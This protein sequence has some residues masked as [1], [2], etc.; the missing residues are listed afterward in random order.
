M[1]W[2]QPPNGGVLSLSL[3][4]RQRVHVKVADALE[5]FYQGHL[6]EHAADLA[7]HLY[8]AGAAADA[9]RTIRFLRMA[10]ESALESAAADEAFYYFDTALSMDVEDDQQK[11]DLLFLRGNAYQGRGHWEQPLTDWS[12]A[13]DLYEAVGDVEGISRVASEMTIRLSWMLR[14]GELS[15]IADRGLRAIGDAPTRERALLLAASGAGLALGGYRYFA[16]AEL[17]ADAETLATELGDE[18]LLGAV[19]FQKVYA[20]WGFI[21]FPGKYD[22]ATRGADLFRSAGLTWPLADIL[23]S[24]QL[25]AFSL[26]R[27]DEVARIAEELEPLARRLDQWSAQLLYLQAMG[28]RELLVTGDTGL[29]HK[30]GEEHL[31]LCDKVGFPWTNVSY[32]FMGLADFWRGRRSDALKKLENACD[33][34]MPGLFAGIATASLFQVRAFFGEAEAGASFREEWLPTLGE[35]SGIGSWRYLTGAVQ[36][37]SYLGEDDEAAKLYPLTTQAID[38]G[39]IMLHYGCF[40]LFEKIAGIA[41]TAARNWPAATAHFENALKQAEAI[42]HKLDQCEVRYW[43]GKMLAERN[44]PGDRDKARQLLGEAIEGYGTLGMPRHLEMAKT[45]AAKL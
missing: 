4:K 10:G 8:E 25:A 27:L 31:A 36:A 14:W 37:F 1:A 18:A 13:F 35:P 43:Y 19:L 24:T 42:P 6:E 11:A 44:A 39:T 33:V 40:D 7:L 3:P 41:A 15:E 28:P 16:G 2:I 29:F 23:S 30:F 45:L 38:T 26:G 12:Q 9:S 21:Q 20:D 32:D 5:K 17:L 34:E 22:A